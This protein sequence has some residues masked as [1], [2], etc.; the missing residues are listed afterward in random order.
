MGGARPRREAWGARVP[1]PRCPA[2]TSVCRPGCPP[3]PPQA[4][5]TA[6]LASSS[7]PLHLPHPAPCIPRART[8][9]LPGL[10]RAETPRAAHGHP[11]SRAGRPGDAVCGAARSLHPCS[12]GR[13]S[14]GSETPGCAC[15][16]GNGLWGRRG[17]V[18]ARPPGGRPGSLGWGWGAPPAGAEREGPGAPSRQ[19]PGLQDDF[20]SP[21]SASTP[22]GPRHRR[23]HRH[24]P[25]ARSARSPPRW[26][27]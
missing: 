9:P 15:G 18:L 26:P 19:R 4:G 1:A 7:S 3:C 10:R 20:Q 6:A 24:L 27:L 13:P 5:L 23:A 14:A 8:S 22:K 11:C 16:L 2:L 21:P 25:T 12:G 17:Q